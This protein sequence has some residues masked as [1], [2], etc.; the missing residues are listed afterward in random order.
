MSHPHHE[1]AP[2]PPFSLR[3]PRGAGT[4]G[5]PSPTGGVA[6]APRRQS[7][8]GATVRGGTPPGRGALEALETLPDEGAP[9]AWRA[10]VRVRACVRGWGSGGVGGHRDCGCMRGLGE[11][12]CRPVV[13]RILSPPRRRRRALMCTGARSVC[14]CYD[15]CPRAARLPIWRSARRCGGCCRG[16]AA[17]D[18]LAA[19]HE[20][21]AVL[22]C[23]VL[24]CA[25]LCVCVC[26]CVCVC[27]TCT[28]VYVCVG[29][30]ICAC[31][32]VYLRLCAHTLQG[33]CA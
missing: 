23:A 24:C 19:G 8:T 6:R 15:Y 7:H 9:G 1:G 22:C 28:C 13:D 20:V 25:V 11:R 5:L 14:C 3:L 16:I 18:E 4:G 21:C 32:S 12:Q 31:V 17:P 33:M 10:H 2:R 26:V 27:T 29:M 30:C